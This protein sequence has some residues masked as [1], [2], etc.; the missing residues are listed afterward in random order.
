MQKWQ[1]PG[2]QQPSRA[3][4]AHCGCPITCHFCIIVATLLVSSS[5][6][7]GEQ[8]LSFG[9]ILKEFTQ[10]LWFLSTFFQKC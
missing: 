4:K 9:Y 3:D 8:R 1:M 10:M 2:Q 5:F 7:R 6:K